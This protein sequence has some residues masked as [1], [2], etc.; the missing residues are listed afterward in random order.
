M[1]HEL[2]TPLNAI[3]GYAE[4]IEMGIRGPVTD[5]QRADLA[6]IQASQRHLLGLINEVLNYARLEA[7]AVQYDLR[8]V[9]VA[10][11][12]AGVESLVRPQVRAKGL[13]LTVGTCDPALAV[14]ADADKLGQVLLNLLSNAVK[15]ADAGAITISCR[16]SGDRVEVAVADTGVGIPADQLEHIFEPFVQVGRALNAPVEGT[17]L[18]LAISR[19]LARGMGGELTVESTLGAGSTFR[20]TLPSA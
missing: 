20:V 12:L 4:L 13:A 8:A 18:G 3:G 14:R 1:S 6:R 15:F 7:G 19:D 11:V 9:P 5:E 10:G 16:A 17:G 2:R